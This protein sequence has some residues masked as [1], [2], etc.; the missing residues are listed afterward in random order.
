MRAWAVF[1]KAWPIVLD[2]LLLRITT[3]STVIWCTVPIRVLRT[4]VNAASV[5]AVLLS[6]SVRGPVLIAVPRAIIPTPIVMAAI[7]PAVGTSDLAVAVGAM[8]RAF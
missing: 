4:A 2:T 7:S 1:G 8:C 3:L 5:V 6:V